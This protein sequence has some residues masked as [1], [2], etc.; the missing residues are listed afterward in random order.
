MNK[1]EL[2]FIYSKKR[3]SLSY[4]EIYNRSKKICDIFFDMDIYINSEKIFTYINYKSEFVSSIIIERA[5][6]DNKRVFVPVMSKSFGEMFFL[7]IKSFDE[8]SA[9]KYGILEPALDFNNVYKPDCK[10]III[11]P[12]LAFDRKCFRLGY[13]GGFYDRFLSENKGFLNIGFAFDF[14]IADEFPHDSF[15]V[16][17]DMILSEKEIIYK[18]FLRY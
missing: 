13:G 5:F 14:Q 8:L 18:R 1:K 6:N 3:N 15:D 11:V 4:D 2:R 9:N 17:V 7:E 16:P 12:A 10:T